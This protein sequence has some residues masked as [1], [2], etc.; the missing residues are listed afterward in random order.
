MPYS[1][2]CTAVDLRRFLKSMTKWAV[3]GAPLVTQK[4]AERR[5]SICSGCD[6][7]KQVPGCATC[8]A[9]A[10][11]LKF[12]RRSQSTSKD[13]KLKGCDVCCC[14]LKTKV[15]FP[16]DA[17]DNNKLKYPPHCWQN[18]TNDE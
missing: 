12:L 11:L 6:E 5:A 4:E 3:K 15:W 2:K 18:T 14:E 16:L 8:T 10:K 9:S 13:D 17:I 1:R 7:N